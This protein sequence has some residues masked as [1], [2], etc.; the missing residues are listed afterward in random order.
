MRLRWWVVPPLALVLATALAEALGLVTA[1]TGDRAPWGEDLRRGLAPLSQLGPQCPDVGPGT[2]PTL[3][4]AGQVH[5]LDRVVVDPVREPVADLG[6]HRLSQR[7]D[8]PSA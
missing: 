2:Q 8:L 3:P 1:R 7:V 6:E 5:P 4:R